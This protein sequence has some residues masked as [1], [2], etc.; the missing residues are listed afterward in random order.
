MQILKHIIDSKKKNKKLISILIDPDKIDE[1]K[2][3][4]T[5]QLIKMQM[6]Y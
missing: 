1:R 5:T 4:Q 6:D 3:I 2:L